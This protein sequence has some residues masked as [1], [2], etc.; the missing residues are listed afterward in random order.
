MNKHQIDGMFIQ[1]QR[2]VN[3]N[4]LS[5]PIFVS[6]PSPSPNILQSLQQNTGRP[7]SSFTSCSKPI[8]LHRRYYD[9]NHD[10]KMAQS[11]PIID[12]T[13]N[14]MQY[15]PVI[16]LPEQSNTNTTTIRILSNEIP[17]TSPPRTQTESISQS[18]NEYNLIANAFENA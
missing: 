4:N 11:E 1:R 14:I 18:Q 2:T 12:N 3:Q 9:P 10:S 8:W 5:S 16:Q 6:S 17:Q 13:T 7:E 15:P